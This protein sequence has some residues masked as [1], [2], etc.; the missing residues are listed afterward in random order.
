MMHYMSHDALLFYSMNKT[1]VI[2]EEA[3]KQRVLDK[4][5]KKPESN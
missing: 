5:K 2:L 1:T 3:A 4:G